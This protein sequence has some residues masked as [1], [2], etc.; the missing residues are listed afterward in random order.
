MA[1]Q[2]AKKGSSP[3]LWQMLAQ[4]LPTSRSAADTA[5]RQALFKQIDVNGNGLLSLAEVDLGLKSILRCE[6]LFSIKPV[7]LRA[8]AAARNV[9]S[10]LIL[11]FPSHFFSLARW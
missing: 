7:I 3:Q 2:I 4:K 5:K 8:Y 6:E 10:F 11:I 9:G 1:T